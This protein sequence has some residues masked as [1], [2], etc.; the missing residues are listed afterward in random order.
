M[1]EYDADELLNE[2]IEIIEINEKSVGPTI[3]D[4]IESF[5]LEGDDG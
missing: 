4:F 5:N 3:K 2:L 1:Q